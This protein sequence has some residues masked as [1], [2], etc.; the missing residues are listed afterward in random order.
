MPR[1]E[2]PMVPAADFTSYY[3]RPVL[4]APVWHSPDIPGYLFLGGLAGATSL[5]AA[6]AQLSGRGR[7]AGRAKV[8]AAGAIALSGLA[9]VHDL[10]R[11]ERFANMLRVAKLSSPMSVGS[12]LLAGYGPA[13]GGAAALS[14]A[15][16][17]PRLGA[18]ATGTAAVI[19]PGISTYTAALLADTAVPAWHDAYPYLPFLFAGSS[20]AAAG[21]IA[22]VVAPL[23]E[24]APA[25]RLG[26]L[27]AAVETA[28]GQ[29][30]ER[31]LGL[32]GEPYSK[33][34]AG[35]LLRA[36]RLLT[37]VGAGLAVV[38]RRRRSLSVL[39]G[40]SLAAS[41]ACTRFGV[42]EAGRQSAA[43]PRYTVIPQRAA[44]SM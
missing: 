32:V 26:V 33:G 9:L 12:W 15:G 30:L 39:A 36:A 13:A 8:V 37:V 38:G 5:L 18:L 28:A 31:R 21:G 42:F 19:G 1:G 4:K 17:L 29:G 3:G 40:L 11:P 25:R 14:V 43:D 44:A 23:D 10:G 6:G 27:G 35:S 20:A 41:S 7:L 24:S 34:K 16:R 22:M 2:R